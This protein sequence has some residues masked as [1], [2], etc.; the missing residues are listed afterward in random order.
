MYS[1]KNDAYH[2]YIII[3]NSSPSYKAQFGSYAMLLA[4]RCDVSKVFYHS[5]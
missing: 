5:P 3:L 1:I 2:S 4:G